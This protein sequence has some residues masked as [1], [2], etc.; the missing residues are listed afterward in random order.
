M[1][2]QND[3]HI[4]SFKNTSIWAFY[5]SKLHR[6]STSKRRGIFAHQNYSKKSTSKWRR[7]FA[8]RNYVEQNTSKQRLFF[9]FQSY[10]EKL[11]WNDVEI[12][13]YFLLTYRR[14]IDIELTSIR[15]AVSIGNSTIYSSSGGGYARAVSITKTQETYFEKYLKSDSQSTSGTRY[16]SDK[17][18]QS[19][20]Q[21]G[22]LKLPF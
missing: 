16:R 14:N 11:S 1:T 6:K 21:S 10:I 5:P 19:F 7:F 3:H 20:K 22:S 13:W 4:L 15:R 8:H 18:Y 2:Y 17:V 9:A 12:R